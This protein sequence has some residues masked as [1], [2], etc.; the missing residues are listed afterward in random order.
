MKLSPETKELLFVL[1]AILLV[2]LCYLLGAY[3]DTISAQT[4][5][6]LA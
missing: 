2:C 1:L 4:L 5:R 6:S 3:L